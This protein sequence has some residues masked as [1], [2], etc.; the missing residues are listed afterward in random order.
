MTGGAPIGPGGGWGDRVIPALW[1][2]G[3][4]S[5]EFR[6]QAPW[7][8]PLGGQPR[9]RVSSQEGGRHDPPAVWLAEGWAEVRALATVSLGPSVL[10]G[11]A[12]KF[13]RGSEGPAHF[14][15]LN[16]RRSPYRPGCRQGGRVSLAQGLGVPNPR[17][18]GPGPLGRAFP[19][20]S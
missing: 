14:P 18:A 2:G 8:G 1:L 12:L 7:E 16:D 3:P 15:A 20:L 17:R 10:A 13:A 4:Q 5:L 19:G 11:G 6:R 9:V